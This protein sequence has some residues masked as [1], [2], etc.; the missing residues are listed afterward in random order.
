MEYKSITLFIVTLHVVWSSN[1][2][3]ED[4]N[5]LFMGDS[6]QCN[7]EETWTFSHAPTNMDNDNDVSNFLTP[8]T[9]SSCITSHA[10]PLTSKGLMEVNIYTKSIQK[11]DFVS[12]TIYEAVENNVVGNATL[13]HNDFEDGWNSLK[14]T[15]DGAG[16][17]EGYVS[18]LTSYYDNVLSYLRTRRAYKTL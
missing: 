4:L 5:T 14:I 9:L 3:T 10:L 17:F 8:G 15:L 7:T 18:I 6:R 11:N 16:N 12:V 1:C 2:G 13:F